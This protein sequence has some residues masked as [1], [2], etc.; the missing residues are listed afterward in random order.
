MVMYYLV[1]IK[2]RKGLVTTD[3]D[4]YHPIAIAS[5][6]LKIVELNNILLELFPT[7]ND[8]TSYQFGFKQKLGSNV[9]I[10]TLV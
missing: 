8:T 9:C 1:I 6:E 5:V 10:F 2:S 7:K 4:N 3:K